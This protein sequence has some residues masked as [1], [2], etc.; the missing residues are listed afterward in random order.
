[1]KTTFDIPD[2]LLRR[3]KISAAKAGTSMRSLVVEG[4]ASAVSRM[5]QGEEESTPRWMSAFGGMR[6]H[7]KESARILQAIEDEFER[8]DE[9][10]WK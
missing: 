1:M 6:K 10:A 4:L 9:E 3:A 7:R 8:I 2:D 5:E